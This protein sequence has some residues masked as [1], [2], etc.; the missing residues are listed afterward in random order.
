MT[1]TA[2]DFGTCK[3]TRSPKARLTGWSQEIKFL[4]LSGG[5]CNLRPYLSP[6]LDLLRAISTSNILLLPLNLARPE[7]SSASA[8]PIDRYSVEGAGRSGVRVPQ[9]PRSSCAR[10]SRRR[11][12]AARRSRARSIQPRRTPAPLKVPESP[13]RLNGRQRSKNRALRTRRK[14]MPAALR[15]PSQALNQAS[16]RA[17]GLR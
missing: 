17:S 1:T 10:A 9:R 6:Q 15:L 7:G 8:L 3:L 5:R 2:F 14:V 4:A 13:K 11:R 12:R 16:R